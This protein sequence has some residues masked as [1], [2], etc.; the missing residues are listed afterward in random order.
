MKKWFRKNWYWLLFGFSA[1]SAL[2]LI[3]VLRPKENNALLKLLQKNRLGYLK[4]LED[5]GAIQKETEEKR[6]QA[7]EEHK[8]EV[9]ELE[10][11]HSEDLVALGQAKKDMQEKLSSESSSVLAAKLKEEFK[12]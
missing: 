7:L 5:L 8:E 9:L 11:K 3:V 6:E 12:I 4:Q 10:E 2:V 1:V